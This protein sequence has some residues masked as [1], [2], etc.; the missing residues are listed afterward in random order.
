MPF[1]PESDPYGKKINWR[2]KRAKIFAV[3]EPFC[4]RKH[5]FC[6]LNGLFIIINNH[7]ASVD[8]Y[9]HNL[10]DKCSILMVPYLLLGTYI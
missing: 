7:T 5:N 8:R 3:D 9:V 6:M 1:K 2:A 4:T 10:Q